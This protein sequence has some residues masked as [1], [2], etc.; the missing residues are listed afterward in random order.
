MKI[1]K[2]KEDD[3]PII[4]FKFV[5]MI[6][7]DLDIKTSETT[8]DRSA[9]NARISEGIKKVFENLSRLSQVENTFSQKILE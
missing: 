4:L 7:S 5:Q 2:F 3:V 8:A 6:I 1:H 9:M